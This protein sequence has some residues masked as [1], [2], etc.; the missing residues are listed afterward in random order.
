M[1]VY[2]LDEINLNFPLCNCDFQLLRLILFTI[3]EKVL[4]YIFRISTNCNVPIQLS[5]ICIIKLT[6]YVKFF[7]YTCRMCQLLEILVINV[8]ILSQVWML[9]AKHIKVCCNKNFAIIPV[10]VNI[11]SVKNFT[12]LLWRNTNSQVII[13]QK[14]ITPRSRFSLVNKYSFEK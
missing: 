2:V 1:T 11:Y 12:V 3:F 8:S 7:S 5:D 14:I 10:I 13:F 4:S 6:F 9:K